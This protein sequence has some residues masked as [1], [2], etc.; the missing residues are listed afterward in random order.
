MADF[1]IKKNSATTIVFP[2]FDADGD[3][4]TAATGLDSEY[5]L[6]GGNFADCASEATEIQTSGIYTLALTAGETNGDLVIIQCKTTT[7]GAKTT[8][9]VFYTATRQLKD[10]MYHDSTTIYG[11]K[12]DASGRLGAI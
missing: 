3:L 6:D 4:V 1:P 2:I 7:V 10:M 12:L 8:V 9:L 11:L 5:S